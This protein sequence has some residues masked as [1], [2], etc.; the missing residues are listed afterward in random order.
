MYLRSK[1]HKILKSSF[2]FISTFIIASGCM[3]ANPTA[4]GPY[5]ETYKAA[6]KSYIEKQYY[7]PYS[8]RSVAI[9]EPQQGHLYF[10][11]GWVV[12]LQANAKNRFGAYVG[13]RVTALL[14][15][16]NTVTQDMV[17]APLCKNVFLKPWPEMEARSG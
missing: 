13:R 9:S 5:P 3:N 15:N 17:D 8:M 7:D 12:C 1:I 4:I 10:Q 14:I 2:I 6:V 11:Q 16:N